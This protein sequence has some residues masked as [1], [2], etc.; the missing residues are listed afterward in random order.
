MWINFRKYLYFGFHVMPEPSWSIIDCLSIIIMSHGCHGI[1][2]HWQH[3]YSFNSVFRLSAKEMSKL[4]ITGPLWRESTIDW[5]NPSQ[6]ARNVENFPMTLSLFKKDMNLH[7][8]LSQ[9]HNLFIHGVKASSGTRHEIDIVCLV[10]HVLKIQFIKVTF[11]AMMVEF[12][13]DPFGFAILFNYS[14]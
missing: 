12:G 1:S 7:T 13:Q 10:L 3:D 8:L 11:R 5:W 6:K 9:Y 4:P 2:Y 14:C